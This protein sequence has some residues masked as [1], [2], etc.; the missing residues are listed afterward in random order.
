MLVVL[1]L[2]APHG[3]ANQWGKAHWERTSDEEPVSIE[4][5]NQ[6]G[7]DAAPFIHDVIAK[8]GSIQAGNW[9]PNGPARAD[10][11]FSYVDGGRPSCDPDRYRKG[12]VVFCLVGDDHEANEAHIKTTKGHILGGIIHIKDVPRFSQAVFCHEF[13]HTLGLDHSTSTSSC[14]M[15]RPPTSTPDQHDLHVSGEISAHTH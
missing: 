13:G 3:D 8:W 1:V 9:Y 7:E 15:G 11:S 6:I 4:L 2:L 5:W 12:V 10:F 14:M